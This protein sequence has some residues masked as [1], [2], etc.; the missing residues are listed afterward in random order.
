M[1][2]NF[3]LTTFSKI[4]PDLCSYPIILCNK[5][6]EKA[7]DSEVKIGSHRK[8]VNTSYLTN[9]NGLRSLNFKLYYT[10][11]LCQTG[12]HF[13]FINS[14]L[15]KVLLLSWIFYGEPTLLW[16]GRITTKGKHCST[17]SLTTR[18]M[19]AG[20]RYSLWLP[21]G[22]GSGDMYAGMRN[23]FQVFHLWGGKLIPETETSLRLGREGWTRENAYGGLWSVNSENFNIQEQ[24]SNSLS[25]LPF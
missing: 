16:K 9:K 22:L 11:T 7:A 23:L 8:N 21:L 20:S 1:S 5:F 10:V 6:K 3:I 19:R 18:L 12:D 14:S 17:V 13:R 24:L 15:G 25:V 4:G 2:G